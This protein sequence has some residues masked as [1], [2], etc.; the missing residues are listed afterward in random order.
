MFDAKEKAPPAAKITP[1]QGPREP[2]PGDRVVWRP[3]ARFD[4]P[5]HAIVSRAFGPRRVN[6][7]VLLGTGT[8]VA[9]GPVD[10]GHTEGTWSWPTD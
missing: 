8:W 9:E 5:L 3:W 2:K 7:A 10:F 1:I 6:I 4:E